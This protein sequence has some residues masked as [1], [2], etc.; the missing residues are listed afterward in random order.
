MII[1]PNTPVRMLL[2]D[3]RQKIFTT[4]LDEIDSQ[5]YIAAYDTGRL[6]AMREATSSMIGGVN[7]MTL[8]PYGLLDGESYTIKL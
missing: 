6:F 4:A 5:I 2:H 1:F 7:R 3:V 8:L